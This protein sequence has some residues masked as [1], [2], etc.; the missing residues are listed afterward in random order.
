MGGYAGLAE[1]MAFAVEFTKDGT[2][3]GHGFV[4]LCNM[5]QRGSLEDVAER[6]HQGHRVL[7]SEDVK[8]RIF[9]FSQHLH[10]E[11]HYDQQRH[12]SHSRCICLF[13]VFVFVGL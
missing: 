1:A 10:R 3:H 6:L 9:R 4:A 2:P 11:K 13:K 5:Y 8:Q 12:E 7:S